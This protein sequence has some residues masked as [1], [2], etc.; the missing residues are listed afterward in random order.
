VYLQVKTKETTQK[1]K[2]EG[3]VDEITK[4][5][6]RRNKGNEA[7]V[8][9]KETSNSARTV[10]ERWLGARKPKFKEKRQPTD[11]AEQELNTQRTQ[12]GIL[13]FFKGKSGN[14]P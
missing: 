8:Q 10:L 9:K 14:I 7:D 6:Y 2:N 13:R 5:P 11:S 12:V 1:R 3:K 4:N